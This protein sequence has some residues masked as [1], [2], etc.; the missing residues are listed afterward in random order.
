M[1]QH[2]MSPDGV[3][4]RALGKEELALLQS[5]RERMGQV[6]APV[7]LESAD[8]RLFFVAMD[9]TGNSRYRDRP[10]NHTVVNRIESA[11]ASLDD[12]AIA[13]SYIEGVGTQRDFLI[14]SVDGARAVTLDTRA[15]KAYYELCVQAKTWREQNPDARIGV[16][17]SGFSRGAESLAIVGRLVDERGIRDPTGVDATFDKDG[18]LTSI[19]W[20]DIP[21][22]EPPG[23]IPS[24]FVLIDPVSTGQFHTE[25]KLPASNVGLVQ[26][27]SWLEHRN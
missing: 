11:L 19:F 6:R 16:A 17:G 7:L 21:P 5:A 13:T 9:G 15:E 22:L 1:D 20:P 2:R 27:T 10:E 8:D 4:A 18:V 25:R 23:S 26:F 12:S 24:A 3:Q 14:R